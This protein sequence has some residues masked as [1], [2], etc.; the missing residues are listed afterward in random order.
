MPLFPNAKAIL[1]NHMTFKYFEPSKDIGPKNIPEKELNP[2]KWR[3]YD[4]NLDAIKEQVSN[5][6]YIGGAKDMTQEQFLEN[7]D[8]LNVLRAYIDRTKN[9][10]PGVGKYDPKPIEDHL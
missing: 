8:F 5:N 10:K 1:P 4:V 7:E 2:G 9:K 3:Y 6:I